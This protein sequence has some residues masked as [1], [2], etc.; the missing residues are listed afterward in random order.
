YNTVQESQ[1]FHALIAAAIINYRQIQTS[2][3]CYINSFH[4][5]GDKM[6]RSYEIN[7]MASVYILDDEHNLC[8]FFV[9][10]GFSFAAKTELI[11]LAV[12]TFH[13]AIAEKYRP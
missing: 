6:G 13:I 8:Q 11:V 7:I 1:C 2:L 10:N 9:G 12:N 3:N 4:Y 5:I